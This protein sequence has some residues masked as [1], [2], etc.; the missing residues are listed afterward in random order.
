MLPN[1][2]HLGSLDSRYMYSQRHLY[3]YNDKPE[4]SKYPYVAPMLGEFNTLVPESDKIGDSRYMAFAS[5][6][7][8]AS[9]FLANLG[10]FKGAYGV[11]ANINSSQL[12]SGMTPRNN[13]TNPKLLV[14][15]LKPIVTDETVLEIT[16]S[17]DHRRK[18]DELTTAIL[19]KQSPD[20]ANS[21][22][23]EQ[24]FNMI[25]M[26]LV[27]FNPSGFMR[28]V[29]LTNIY[30]YCYTFEDMACSMF[31]I[32]NKS[33]VRAPFPAGTDP[34][35]PNFPGGPPQQAVRSS[36]RSRTHSSTFFCD[37][38]Q[39]S[40]RV[41]IRVGVRGRPPHG[42]PSIDLVAPL[43]RIFR[44]DNAL[45]LGTPKFLSDQIFNKV[46]FQSVYPRSMQAFN[47]EGGPIYS[48]DGCSSQ[49]TEVRG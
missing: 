2:C 30:N 40:I 32:T 41:G 44:G 38:T 5:K 49:A 35:M 12:W 39:M 3:L 48:L 37:H 18:L 29:P 22:A 6:A 7:I 16:E 34:L 27:P 28:E 10:F 46:L 25:D 42:G 8:D 14:S 15:Q 9:R 33:S 4:G 23:D 13:V 19:S 20:F 1:E 17:M 11:L 43:Q 24:R 21:R 31:G 36:H 26:N 45:N 47:E